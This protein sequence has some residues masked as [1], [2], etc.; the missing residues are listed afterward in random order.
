MANGYKMKPGSK[1]KNTPGGFNQKQTD[2]NGKL[3]FKLNR[4]TGEVGLSK[5]QSNIVKNIPAT[6]LDPTGKEGKTIVTKIFKKQNLQ[7]AYDPIRK[8]G[9]KTL[10]SLKRTETGFKGSYRTHDKDF[11][12]YSKNQNKRQAIRKRA[13]HKAFNREENPFKTNKLGPKQ[14]IK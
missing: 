12:A 11:A 4:S 2:T 3:G 10:D 1:E 9:K 5:K 8:S 13:E 14:R 7:K 6:K